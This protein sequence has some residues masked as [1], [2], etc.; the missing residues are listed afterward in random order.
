[1]AII[2]VFMKTRK[3]R[4]ENPRLSKGNKPDAHSDKTMWDTVLNK[5]EGGTDTQ[6]RSL[7]SM[8]VPWHDCASAFTPT[9]FKTLE[10]S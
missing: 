1:M 5:I 8:P 10:Y 6:R 4:Q 2:L 3:W 9:I 7:N